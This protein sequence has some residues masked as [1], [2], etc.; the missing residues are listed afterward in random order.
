M[1]KFKVEYAPAAYLEALAE[2]DLNEN[3]DYSYSCTI[4]GQAE[5]LSTVL[6]RYL[7]DGIVPSNNNYRMF[8]TDDFHAEVPT[9]TP[10]NHADIDDINDLQD[11]VNQAKSEYEE[12][13]KAY[14]EYIATQNAANAQ[15]SG[16]TASDAVN[17]MNSEQK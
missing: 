14:N 3:K 9:D 12:K 15:R 1:A 16:A 11:Q 13:V 4:P 17:N 6:D 5:G 10:E 2:I 7:R 8:D